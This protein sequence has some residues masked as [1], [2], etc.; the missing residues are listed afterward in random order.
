MHK[1]AGKLAIAWTL[2]LATAGPGFADN[3]TSGTAR[4]VA[5]NA[6]FQDSLG[7]GGMGRPAVW[8][9]TQLF[10]GRSYQVSVWSVREDGGFVL[11][12]PVE[13][14]A[15][16]TMAPLVTGVTTTNGALEG[17]P[18]NATLGS[19]TTVFQPATTGL[20]WIKA[21]ADPMMPLTAVNV[22]VRETT[23]FSPWLSKAAGFE[24]FIELHNNTNAALNVTLKAYDSL[25]AQQGSG[26]T[27]SLPQNATV[28]Q[29]GAL[30][31]VPVGVAAGVVLT[32]N[33]AFGAVSGNITTLN[34]ANGLSFDS[35]FTAREAGGGS[36]GAEGVGGA[37]GA[38]GATGPAGPAGPP[39]TFSAAACTYVTGPSI[40]G[41]NAMGTL[42]SSSVSCPAGQIA[43][44]GFPAWFSWSASSSCT[45]LT[46]RG[47]A[48]TW[49][50]DWFSTPAGVGSGC[51]GNTLATITLCCP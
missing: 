42:N 46:R 10:A 26:L 45:P 29:T 19:R 28:F 38:T 11:I 4:S 20:Y 32:H 48:T 31:G 17:S 41:T 51:A 14:Y 16:P 30:I 23:L 15:D 34:G 2:V 37:T 36:D 44:G 22:L 35:P 43:I 39:G 3:L 24:G 18:N 27:F 13:L 33:G 7:G 49:F 40:V 5:V 21:S 6:K 1:N 25:G 12:G 50:T 9:K 8:Y 47:S